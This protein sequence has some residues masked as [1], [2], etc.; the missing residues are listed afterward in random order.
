VILAVG[1]KGPCATGSNWYEG[2]NTPDKNGIIKPTGKMLGGHAY[3][4]RGV[5]VK[6]RLLRIKNSWGKSFGIDGDCFI[7]FDDMD[8]LLKERGEAYIP[9]IRRYGK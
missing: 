7:S 1:Y 9:I 4:I 8:R 6:A 2:M 3:V 5:N